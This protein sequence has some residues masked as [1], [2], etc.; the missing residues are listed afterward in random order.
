[1]ALR[2]CRRIDDLIR[3]PPAIGIVTNH[4]MPDGG[5]VHPDLM[6]APRLAAAL[7]ERGA[8]VHPAGPT[9]LRACTHLDVSAA[10]AEFAADALRT[11]C[12]MPAPAPAR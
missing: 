9:T 3:P 6:P 4:C 2:V 8:L 7:K 11:V 1:M 10:D 5:K 12:R